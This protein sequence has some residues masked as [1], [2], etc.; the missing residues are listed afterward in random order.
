MTTWF[1]FVTVFAIIGWLT[2][3][4]FT[5]ISGLGHYLQHFLLFG[6]RGLMVVVLPFVEL[7][8]LLLRP[9]TLGVRLSA[10]MTRGHILLC[11]VGLLCSK[12][13]FIL[14]VFVVMLFLCFLEI[15]VSILQGVVF[16]ILVC[17]YQNS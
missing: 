9:V 3:V 12:R 5:C 4:V 10:N 1:V 6:V 13:V 7:I 16:S 11:F 14:L 15:F 8:R 2:V 17:L